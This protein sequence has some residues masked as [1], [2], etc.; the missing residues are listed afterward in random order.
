MAYLVGGAGPG[1]SGVH[2]GAKDPAVPVDDRPIRIDRRLIF[3]GRS[4]R[5]GGGVCAVVRSSDVG[6]AAC[7]GRAWLI[8]A[9]QLLDVWRQ[10]NGGLGTDHPAE[11]WRQLDRQGHVD[12]P[13]GRYRRLDSL[14]P[15]DGI[16]AVTITCG[17]EMEAERNPPT[18]AYLA[19]VSVGLQE[20][21]QLNV[22]EAS[23][24]LARHAGDVIGP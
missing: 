20:A 7:L 5:W 6:D 10:E 21:W 8:T 23:R 1:G 3:T 14:E 17:P 11:P 15:I 24:Y 12:K 13:T 16:R 18:A 9:D 2:I 22:D 4:K 19:M